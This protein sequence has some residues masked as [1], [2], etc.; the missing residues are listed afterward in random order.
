MGIHTKFQLSVRQGGKGAGARRDGLSDELEMR[1]HDCQDDERVYIP[2]MED[3]GWR[4]EEDL[5]Y[6]LQ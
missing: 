1:F 5:T 2:W 6:E 3:G 4:M